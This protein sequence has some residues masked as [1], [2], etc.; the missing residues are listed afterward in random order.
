MIGRPCGLA[1]LT[2]RSAC[3]RG[4]FAAP[5]TRLDQI[6]ALI[7]RNNCAKNGLLSQFLESKPEQTANFGGFKKG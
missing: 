4:A 2:L 1:T 3:R 7:V 5:A 6:I